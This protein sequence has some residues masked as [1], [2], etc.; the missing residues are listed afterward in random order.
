M[1]DT[2]FLFAKPTFFEG[3]ARTIDL[4]AT[5]DEYN[6]SMTPEQA[7]FLAIRNDWEVIGKDLVIAFEDEEK[8]S[9]VKGNQIELEF[10][11]I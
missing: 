7:D 11:K 9:D 1:G 2:S 5:L 4:G 6:S 3:L 8:K 10:G